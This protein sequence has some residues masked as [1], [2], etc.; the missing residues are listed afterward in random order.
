MGVGVAY[1]SFLDT[2]MVDAVEKNPAAMRMRAAMARPVRRT[3]PL[4][5]AVQATVAGIERRATR[6]VY[7][8]VLR[9]GLVLRGLMGPR[10]ESAL[11]KAMPEV[12]RLAEKPRKSD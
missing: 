8:G 11:E 5:P 3:Y 4:E 6:I 10:S 12:E 9:V 7:P 1:Y 2:P